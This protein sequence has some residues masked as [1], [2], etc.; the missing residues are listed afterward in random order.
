MF[1]FI[2]SFFFKEVV[3]PPKK[4]IKKILYLILN[5]RTKLYI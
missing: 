4:K 3:D 1:Y 2:D 5:E